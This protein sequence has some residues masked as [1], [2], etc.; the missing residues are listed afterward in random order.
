MTMWRQRLPGETVWEYWLLGPEERALR[1]AAA[2]QQTAARVGADQALHNTAMQR[3]NA[4]IDHDVKVLQA[5]VSSL[6]QSMVAAGVVDGTKLGDYFQSAME[7]MFPPPPAPAT[8]TA[9]ASTPYRGATPAPAPAPPP[10]IVACAKC[11][12]N[13][14]STQTNV[15]ENGTVCDACY[16]E[17]NKPTD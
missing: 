17:M 7:K 13:V 15:T 16:A 8:R 2:A 6:A 10:V 11:Q 4:E 9:Q 12:K 14:P 3:S 1:A 5:M